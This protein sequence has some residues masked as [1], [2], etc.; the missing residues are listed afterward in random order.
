MTKKSDPMAVIPPSRAAP[1]IERAPLPL[2]EVQGNEHIVSHVNSAFCTLLGMPRA[3]IVGRRFRDVVPGGSTCVPLLDRVYE[4]GNA[5]THA[6][7]DPETDK[8]TWLFAMWPALDPS[9]RPE[10]AIIGLTT[11]QNFRQNV[12]AMNEALLISG[13]REQESREST[14]EL[15]AQLAVEIAERKHVEQELR[16]ANERLAATDRNKDE[17]LAMLAHEL[18]NP[19]APIKNAAQ[20]L[21]MANSEDATIVR[22]QAI[23]ERQASHLAKLVD[24]LLDLSRLQKGKVKLARVHVDLATAVTRAVESCDHL[25]SEQH[26]VITLDLPADGSLCVEADPTRLD[27][28]LVNLTRWHRRFDDTP[29]ARASC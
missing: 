10:G 16:E 19:L 15:N 5:I 6:Q 3:D 27:Q 22:A 21:R 7:E 18:R 23:I 25:I 14:E 24:E 26:H 9:E 20:I 28:V 17:F 29:R 1:I 13:L 4:T 12:T 11:V 2:I 8:T